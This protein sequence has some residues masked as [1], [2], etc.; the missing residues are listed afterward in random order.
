MTVTLDTGT[1][2][3]ETTSNT[4]FMVAE[5]V[6]AFETDS[7]DAEADPFKLR[8]SDGRASALQLRKP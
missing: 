8:P 3:V 4:V 5:N 1:G 7:M 2:T 6:T